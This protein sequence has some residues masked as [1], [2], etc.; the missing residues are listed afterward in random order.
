MRIG[1]LDYVAGNLQSVRNALRNLGYDPAWIKTASDLESLSAKERGNETTI[2]REHALIFPG[3]GEF[4]ACMESLRERELIDPLRAWIDAGRPY[5][6]ICLGYQVLFESSDEAPG[7]SGLG[8][9][10]GKVLRFTRD[11]LSGETLNGEPGTVNAASGGT[12]IPHMGWNE[13]Q[14]ADPAD[15]LWSGLPERPHAY[16]VH[17]YYPVPADDTLVATTTTYGALTFASSIRR[18]N[19]TATQFHPEKS[20][21]VGQ[22][23]LRNFLDQL[24]PA[25]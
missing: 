5:F 1:I 24:V 18:G 8:I 4:A 7:Q 12:K 25:E 16:F 6:G 23:I 20:Q 17:S 14:P 10:K 15:P 21:Q 22:R 2:A 9:F 11:S 13:I 19:L 3:Q